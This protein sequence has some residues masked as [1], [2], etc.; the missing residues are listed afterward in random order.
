[1]SS[2]QPLLLTQADMYVNDAERI[3]QYCDIRALMEVLYMSFRT[4]RTQKPIP[5]TFRQLN[6]RIQRVYDSDEW[7]VDFAEAFS[8]QPAASRLEIV[9][10]GFGTLVRQGWV[11]YIGAKER[12]QRRFPRAVA[13]FELHPDL[14]RLMA[15]RTVG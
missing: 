15:L 4:K 7:S 10:Y 13:Y 11:D 6:N 12:L 14:I 5:F 3:L 9:Q 8:G 1:M 2:I